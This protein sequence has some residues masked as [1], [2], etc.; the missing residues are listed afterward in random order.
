MFET[1]TLSECADEFAPDGSEVR[2]LLRRPGGSLAHFRLLAGKT[3]VA[4]IHR[5]VDE[6]WYI[7]AGHGEMWRRCDGAESIVVLQKGVCL[8]IPAGVA[9][10]FRTIGDESLEAVAVTMPPWSNNDEAQKVSGC[11]KWH[12]V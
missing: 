9:F 6:L 5:T 3:S 12:N 11:K 2:L 8:S 10:Q 7:L 1:K 4:V